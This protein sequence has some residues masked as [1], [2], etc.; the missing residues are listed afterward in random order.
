MNANGSNGNK[1][2]EIC[3]GLGVVTLDVP[4][5]HP[6]FGKAFPCVCQTDKI[7]TRKA[8]Q[9]RSLSNL[10]AYGDKTFATFQVDYSQLDADDAMLRKTCPNLVKAA[11]LTEDQ[12]R[13]ITNAAR[14]ALRYAKE[15]DGWLLLQGTYGTGKT[16]LAVAIANTR[17][18][19]GEA[20]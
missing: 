3:G 17:L 15:P 9:L 1:V 16:H 11:D 12:R 4:I 5:D 6:D 13:Q 19:C 14:F 2:C 8:T 18:S 10:D 20:I 7:K